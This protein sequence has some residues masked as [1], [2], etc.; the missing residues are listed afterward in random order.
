MG[1]STF[2]IYLR[3]SEP[4]LPTLHHRKMPGRNDMGIYRLW[5]ARY[6]IKIQK[7][8]F[9]L[10]LTGRLKIKSVRLES[11][12]LLAGNAAWLRTWTAPGDWTIP[13]VNI[14]HCI[15]QI[16]IYLIVPVVFPC[17]GSTTPSFSTHFDMSNTANVITQE[18]KTDASARWTPIKIRQWT[19]SKVTSEIIISYLGSFWSWSPIEISK[20]PLTADCSKVMP[21]FFQTQSRLLE[22]LA[23][24]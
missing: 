11:K 8:Q 2:R 21:T 12:K 15:F 7:R 24:V 23:P 4:V 13:K 20:A 22:D 14:A 10:R 18:I 9:Y 5:R 19:R 1:K 16:R 6:G 17:T 3:T